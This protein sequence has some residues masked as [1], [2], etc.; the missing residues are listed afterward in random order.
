MNHEADSPV[1]CTVFVLQLRPSLPS[2]R[3]SCSCKRYTSY[4]NTEC[5]KIRQD[6]NWGREQKLMG[7]SQFGGSVS[8]DDM[9][10]NHGYGIEGL[11]GLKLAVV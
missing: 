2:F 9:M 10:S 6:K 7:G 3:P 8:K 1:C 5:N 11:L 4:A